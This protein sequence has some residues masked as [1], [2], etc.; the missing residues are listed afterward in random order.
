MLHQTTMKGKTNEIRNNIINCFGSI[1]FNAANS[2]L[3]SLSKYARC[4]FYIA[5]DFWNVWNNYNL[6]SINNNQQ[7][8]GVNNNEITS[9]K[10]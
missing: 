8:I 6:L 5:N 7:Q 1:I 10:I 4:I 9:Y 2:F 3:F